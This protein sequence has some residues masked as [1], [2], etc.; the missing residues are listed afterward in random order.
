MTQPIWNTSAGSL[1]SFPA[2]LAL[3]IQLSA[4]AQSPAT[5]IQ[6]TLLSGTLP[7]GISVSSGGLLSGTPALVTV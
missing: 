5:S 2:L 1:G 4:S 3:S 6:Y 7:I